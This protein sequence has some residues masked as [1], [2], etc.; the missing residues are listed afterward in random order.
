M[1]VELPG[2]EVTP[3]LPYSLQTILCP[4][5]RVSYVWSQSWLGPYWA[6]VLLAEGGGQ[7]AVSHFEQ[8]FANA[9]TSPVNWMDSVEG[10]LPFDHQHPG[11]KRLSGPFPSLCVQE[12]HKLSGAA[13]SPD[14]C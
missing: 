6:C 13:D 1:L 7:E 2:T 11:L 9:V 3:G 14:E 10:F 4:L 5:P 8:A 12:H